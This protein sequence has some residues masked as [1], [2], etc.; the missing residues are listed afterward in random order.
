MLWWSTS[1]QA[2]LEMQHVVT[3][4]E[5]IFSECSESCMNFSDFESEFRAKI[6]YDA[7]DS[8]ADLE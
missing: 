6:D 3:M 5:L 7:W 4:Y 1:A 8:K 2:W